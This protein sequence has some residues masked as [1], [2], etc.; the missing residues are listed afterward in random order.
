MSDKLG[1]LAA[2]RIEDLYNPD[3]DTIP[4]GPQVTW[5]EY[6]LW[7]MVKG[8]AARVEQLEKNA[9]DTDIVLRRNLSP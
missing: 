5:A 8:L 3:F 9:R 2:Q 4:D 1:R 7:T 6:L